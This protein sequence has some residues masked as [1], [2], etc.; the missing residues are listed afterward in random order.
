MKNGLFILLV[1]NLLVPHFVR[2]QGVAYSQQKVDSLKKAVQQNKGSAKAEAMGE[3]A[4]YFVK[5]P[6]DSSRS[7][8]EQSIAICEQTKDDTTL[9]KI[10]CQAARSFSDGGNPA[11]AGRYLYQ[12]RKLN[13]AAATMPS[14]QV[15][16]FKGLFDLHYWYLT[17]Y[18]SCTY[19]AQ[20]WVDV[21]VDSTNLGWGY[22]ELGVSH[23]ELGN[24][25]KALEY[26]NVARGILSSP[27]ADLWTRGH[28]YNSL[29]MLYASERELDKAADYFLQ[30]LA[31]ARDSKVP[32]ADLPELN[33][34]GLLY[35]WQ[36]KYDLSLKYLEMAAE[37][38]PLRPDAWDVANNLLN[39]GHTLTLAGRPRE[40]LQ[41]LEDA[42]KRFAA[43]KDDYKVA[44]LQLRMAEANRM[45]GNYALAEN[46][47]RQS[48]QWDEEKG[49]GDLVKESYLELSEIYGADK[50]FAKAFEYQRKYI[51]I[52]DS[53][54]STEHR[55]KF[56]LLEK[57]YEIA[58]QEKERDRL[59]RENELHKAQAEADRLAQVL[60]IAGIVVLVAAMAIAVLA[61]KRGRTKTRKIEEQAKQLEEAAEAKSRFFANV[62]H[63]LRTPVT[64]INGMLELIQEKTGQD[65][66]RQ[67]KIAIDSSHRL[68]TMLNEVLNLA[69]VGG[70]KWELVLREKEILPLLTRIVFAFESL[71]VRKKLTFEWDA[72]SLEQLTMAIDEDKFEKIINNLLYNAIKF[73]REGGWVKVTGKRLEDSVCIEVADSGVGIPASELPFVF[74]R[75]FQSRS[76]GTLNTQGLGIGLSLVRELTELHGGQIQVQSHVNQGTTFT[77]TLPNRS[78]PH[79]PDSVEESAETEV[80]SSFPASERKPVVLIVEDND[81][82]RY[83][84]KEILGPHLEI[85]EA[86][87]GREALTW[88]KSSSPDLIISDVM[89]PE[90]DG[91]E[92]LRQLKSNEALRGIPVVMLTARAAEEDLLQG[93]GL[94]VDD[95]IIKPF[96]AKELRIR[97]RNLL[98]NLQIRKEWSAQPVVEEAVVEFPGKDAAL[99]EKMRVF[100][101]ANADKATLGVLDLCDHLAVSE[102]QLYRKMATLAGMTPAQ[103]V[104]EIRLKLAY[105]LLQERRV[106]KVA[107]LAARVGFDNTS[108]FS[109]QFEQ[110]FGKRPAEMLV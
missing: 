61:I 103:A 102:R 71:M 108:Y 1:L 107:E 56:G 25:I 83:Y 44:A 6:S 28:L 33:N 59:Q 47:A 76:T 80:D 49:Y 73:N 90:M 95:Y 81:E 50:Q 54:N 10:L 55:T 89:M 105:R 45:L 93:L 66:D 63:E 85:A 3:L 99:M 38:L 74:D 86:S 30:G 39:R 26:F 12:A 31:F 24:H 84:L 21:A 46:Q 19:Y 60:L 52:I 79:Q 2:A 91:H 75:F 77:L 58:Q 53:L 104:K 40:G 57:N 64:L 37:R 18:D 34:L 9:I 41:K 110:R 43:I 69:R 65:T 92:F 97:I 70:S 82:M 27:H 100:V 16:V 20:K 22:I 94:G 101:E 42:L 72:S 98:M 36:G 5:S 88:L 68:Q 17:N 109:R 51:T 29:G 13:S 23:N 8:I 4:R 67:L 48:L 106:T 78:T 87:H 11:L 62:S 14:F 96:N 32:G 35:N 15:K 7:L